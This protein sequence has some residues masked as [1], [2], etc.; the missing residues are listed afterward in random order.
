MI[1]VTFN[2]VADFGGF[3]ALTFLK[4]FL[5]EAVG[6]DLPLLADLDFAE[7]H[8][9]AAGNVEI[10]FHRFHQ[11][12]GREW[13]SSLATEREVLESSIG[14]WNVCTRLHMKSVHHARWDQR[15]E[16]LHGE[17]FYLKEYII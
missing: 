5:L 15:L 8:F 14:K 13:S 16:F 7:I 11:R 10:F 1:R 17:F 6:A 2:F 4:E 12:R 9:L 3:P